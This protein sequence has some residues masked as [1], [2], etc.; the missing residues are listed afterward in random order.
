M[1]NMSGI[2]GDVQMLTKTMCTRMFCLSPEIKGK[3]DLTQKNENGDQK[4]HHLSPVII[5]E[6]LRR[7]KNDQ[8]KKNITSNG[9]P[10][11]LL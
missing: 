4:R 7:R 8:L 2:S 1:G 9:G 5:F 6:R 10:T 11:K 3:S